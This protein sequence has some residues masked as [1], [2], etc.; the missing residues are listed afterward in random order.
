MAEQTFKSPGF[1]ESEIDLSGAT[2]TEIVGVPAGLAGPTVIGPAFVPVTVG[3]FAEFERRFGGINDKYFGP[4]AVKEFLKNRT[5]LT[6]VRT[7]GAGGNATS[8]DFSL[9]MNQGTVRNAGFIV[10]GSAGS[11]LKKRHRGAVQFIAAKHVLSESQQYGY[12]IF[13]RNRSCANAANADADLK[14]VNLLRAMIFTSTGSCFRIMDYNENYSAAVEG[15]ADSATIDPT[16]EGPMAYRFKL[17]LSSTSGHYADEGKTGLRIYTAS[18]NPSDDFYIAK[19][20][21]TDPEQFQKQEHLL[22]ADFPVEHEVAPVSNQAMA[23][24]LVSGSGNSSNGSGDTSETFLDLFGR[25]DTRYTT[26]R[27]TN[28]ISQPFGDKEYD[29]FHFETI[30]DGA[31]AN[32][33]YKISI[34]NL[35]RSSDD[36]NP[37]GTFTVMVRDF[38]DSDTGP[39]IL[40]QYGNCSLN[41]SSDDYVAKKIG[42]LKVVYNFDAETD[43]EKRLIV[44]GKYP[45]ISSRVRIVMKGEVET[46]DVP[47]GALPFGFR[48]LPVLKTTDTLTDL[49]TTAVKGIYKDPGAVGVGNERL[50]YMPGSGPLVFSLTSSIVPPVPLRFKVTRGNVEE[51]T[52]PLGAK[53][54][55]EIVDNR[56]YWGIKFNRVAETGSLGSPALNPNVGGAANGLIKS[57]SKFL[58]ITKLDALVTGSGAD[59]FNNNKFTLAQVALRNYHSSSLIADSIDQALTG[60]AKEHMIEAFYI[61]DGRPYPDSLSIPDNASTT[62]G[63]ITFGSLAL[64]TSSVKFN[65]FSEYMKFT[66]MFYGGFDGLNILDRDMMRMNDRASSADTG[67]KAILGA[68]SA[69][70]SED[71]G[72]SSNYKYGTGATNNTV[73][74]YRTAARILTDPMASRVNIISIPGIRDSFLTDYVLERANEYGKAIYI[75]D[76]P[77]YD[78]DNNR[79]FDDSS[80]RS[81]VDKTSENF[82]SRALDNNYGAT[83][84]PDVSIQDANTGIVA[85]V[86]SSIAALGAIGFNDSISYPWFAPAGFNRGALDFVAA[87]DAKLSAGDRDTLYESRINPI[88]TFPGAGFVIFGQKTLQQ[89]HT[90]LDRVNV[91]RMLLE[92]KRLVSDVANKIVFEQNTP[93]TRAQFVGQV[94]P[95]LSLV[96][97][98]QGIEQFQVVMDS[99]NN[100]QEDVEQNRLNGRIVLVPTRAVEFIV[101]DF[102]ITNAG[103]SFE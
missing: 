8:G 50:A 39:V 71:I 101:I 6:F 18:L 14:G 54:P 73:A 77:S 4:Y 97:S 80:G 21:N 32:S 12:P 24:G 23:V 63:R 40:E 69:G 92:V 83:Y 70:S 7:L 85:R 31:V 98:Q 46:K 25:F 89:A 45:N 9:T 3:T 42:D 1:F 49:N 68:P 57:Y 66:N 93:A 52:S 38:G 102:V 99:S 56:F 20:L 28:F 59:E 16:G 43:S 11:D 64:L 27:T 86:P 58:G 87:I 82:D 35:K 47:A 91:R 95:L 5:A 96:Q 15:I 17:V 65:K 26:P 48:G 10:E 75:M 2:E 72:L 78:G 67:G 19:V 90:A 60:T 30:S 44:S 103:V 79:L 51:S 81:A 36:A 41:P 53:G 33:K 84:F 34:S 100:T 88:A 62:T 22:Y 37:Y 61:R 94:T 13:T 74:S 76:I 55:T 29:L